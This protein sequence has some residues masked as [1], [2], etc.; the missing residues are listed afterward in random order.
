M[1]TVKIP[2]KEALMWTAI[3]SIGIDI[4]ILYYT[5]R[6]TEQWEVPQ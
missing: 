1:N 5:D 2:L 3:D 4:F 6:T